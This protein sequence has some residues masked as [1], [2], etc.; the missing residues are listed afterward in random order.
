VSNHAQADDQTLG[1]G[2]L[3]E[4]LRS[5]DLETVNQALAE[6]FDSLRLASRFYAQKDFSDRVATLVALNATWRFLMQFRAAL[7]ERLH[8]SLWNLSSA[9]QALNENNVA[10]ILK[11][12]ATPKGGRAVDPPDRQALIGIAVGTVGRL[13]W[14]GIPVPEAHGLVAAELARLG[15]KP[16][17][18]AGRITAR[19]V[20]QWCERVSII[21]PVIYSILAGGP[22]AL[23]KAEPG[24]MAQFAA[25]QNADEMLSPKW[26][27]LIERQPRD[28]ARAFVLN[29]LRAAIQQEVAAGNRARSGEKPASPPS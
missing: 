25:V 24:D 13:R 11:P 17:R 14:T 3:P 2:C 5:S 10:P 1:A 28:G 8:L 23:S 20:K 9:L 29:A 19:T 27:S 16:A 12:T 18:G 15:I 22:E 21:R 4:Q 6:L 7:D 26:R